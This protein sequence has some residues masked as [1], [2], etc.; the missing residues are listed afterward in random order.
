M[1]SNHRSV[2]AAPFE[3]RPGRTGWLL[4]RDTGKEIKRIPEPSDWLME[5]DHRMQLR[6]LGSYPRDR[7]RDMVALVH[8]HRTTPRTSAAGKAA[9]LCFHYAQDIPNRE[10]TLAASI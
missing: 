7:H 3:L 8:R 10:H 2:Y 9:T 6:E 1:M 4:A 5:H